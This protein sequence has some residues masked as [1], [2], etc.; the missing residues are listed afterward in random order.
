M[1]DAHRHR[2]HRIRLR[3]PWNVFRA[4]EKAVDDA[5]CHVQTLSFPVTW[6]EACGARIGRLRL[7]RR[8]GCPTDLG[9]EEIVWLEVFS[10]ADGQAVLNQISLGNLSR[11][12]QRF[13]V[14]S[15]LRDGNQLDIELTRT[16]DV[17]GDATIVEVA[18]VIESVG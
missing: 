5:E 13:D 3:G 12:T 2:E 1:S 7:R 11:T 10:S 16:E 9:A 6:R 17:E 15:Q 18:L 14:T 8:F 4:S